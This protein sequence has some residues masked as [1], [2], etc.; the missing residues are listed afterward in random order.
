MKWIGGKSRLAPEIASHMPEEIGTYYEP[1]AGGAAVFCRLHTDGR[2]P[3]ATTTLSDSN[4]ALIDLYRDVQRPDT[5]DALIERLSSYA[6]EYQTYDA[7]ALYYVERE[8]WNSAL[9]NSARF[10]FLKQTA[11]NG[12]WRENRKGELNAAWGKYENPTILDE[13]NIR[14]WHAALS[15]VSLR[16][17]P[18]QTT[19]LAPARDAV[20]YADPP[21]YGTFNG[22]GA[23]PFTHGLHV[24]LFCLAHQ[25]SE[26]GAHVLISNS[27]HPE[28]HNLL[29]VILPEADRVELSTSYTVNRDGGGRSQTSELLVK[30]AAK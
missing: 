25:W 21:Y 17:S 23:N 27:N 29:D 16:S 22:Y 20:I 7:E 4:R 26:A 19:P 11:F 1:F 14:E 10:V 12:L 5:R 18:F 9:R 15:G 30:V 8:K 13:D 3:G 6:R 28:V 2:L 24:K